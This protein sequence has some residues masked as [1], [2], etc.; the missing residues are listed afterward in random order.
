MSYF[1]IHGD[2]ICLSISNKGAIIH[3]KKQ[4]SILLLSCFDAIPNLGSSA[5]CV[6]SC[7]IPGIPFTVEAVP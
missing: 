2:N 5:L 3:N 7:G 6:L 4:E 1:F